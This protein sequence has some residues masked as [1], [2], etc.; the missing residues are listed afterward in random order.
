MNICIYGCHFTW[1]QLN[2]IQLNLQKKS[3]GADAIVIQDLY[4][5]QMLL[6]LSHR[7]SSMQLRCI[8]IAAFCGGLSWIPTL[9]F[10]F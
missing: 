2:A 4:T 5:N 8:I 9:I 1:E 7:R 6:P 10:F 3:P